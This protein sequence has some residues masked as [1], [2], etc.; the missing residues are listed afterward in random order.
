M[1]GNESDFFIA[2]DRWKA[3]YPGARAGI[4]VIKN[5]D[6]VPNDPN[7]D[8]FV[9][10]VENEL[11]EKFAGCSRDDFNKIPTIAAY[12]EYYKNFGKT[13]HVRPQVE[14]IAKGKS[15]PKISALLSVMFA[16]EVKNMLLT[17]GHDFDSL[18]LPIHIK[19]AEGG[20]EYIAMN[21]SA[22]KVEKGDM[23]MEDGEAIVSSIIQGPDARTKITADT[24]D[25]LFAIYAPAGIEGEAIVA[26]LTD[27]QNAIK[28]FSSAAKTELL[29]VFEAK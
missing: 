29:E 2:D 26:H 23:F 7:V 10:S 21:G 11:R 18:Q 4:L 22:K 28:S 19:V 15:L 13:Y 17:A 20:E 27:I 8:E 25:A 16:A 5:I 6:N 12:N 9:E 3:A 1:Q 24:T 14:S